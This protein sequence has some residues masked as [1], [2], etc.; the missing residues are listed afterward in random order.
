MHHS[1]TSFHELLLFPHLF[2]A[3][4]L[5]LMDD[6][7]SLLAPHFSLLLWLEPVALKFIL[8]CIGIEIEIG[9][10]KEKWN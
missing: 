2:K 10:E 3:N 6:G 1:S 7:K 9:I 5:I 4:I 8:N